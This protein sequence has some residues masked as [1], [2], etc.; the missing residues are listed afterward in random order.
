MS[1]FCILQRCYFRIKADKGKLEEEECMSGYPR[2]QRKEELIL[3][4][5]L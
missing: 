2:G 1:P 5:E 4:E 3:G